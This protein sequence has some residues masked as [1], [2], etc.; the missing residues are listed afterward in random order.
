M[1]SD[2]DEEI[3][4]GVAVKAMH[5]ESTAAEKVIVSSTKF[6]CLRHGRI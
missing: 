6:K 3:C 4:T 1:T 5:E 2:S